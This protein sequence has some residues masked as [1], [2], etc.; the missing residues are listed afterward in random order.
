MV[1]V[2]VSEKGNKLKKCTYF[3]YVDENHNLDI[4]MVKVDHLN[5]H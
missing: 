3:Y 4:S 1:R 2:G 5:T